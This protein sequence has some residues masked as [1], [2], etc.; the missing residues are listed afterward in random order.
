MGRS[1]INALGRFHPVRALAFIVL[2]PLSAM[3]SLAYAGDPK[4]PAGA[5]PL[6]DAEIRSLLDGK[7]FSFIAYDE[8]LTGTTSWDA[9]SGTVSGDYVVKQAQGGIYTQGWFV[10]EGKNCT[11]S[12]GKKAV[13]HMIYRYGDG[14]MEVN[15]NGSAHSVSVPAAQ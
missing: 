4:I 3:T 6:N 11:Q 9:Q 14:F 10:G 2:I 8:L 12:P 13:C 15:E 1:D 7:K 5:Q